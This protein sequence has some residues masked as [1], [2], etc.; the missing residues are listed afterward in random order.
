MRPSHLVWNQSSMKGITNLFTSQRPDG[1]GLALPS[2]SDPA[3]RNRLILAAVGIAT[4]FYAYFVSKTC[5]VNTVPT[6]LFG[7]LLGYWTQGQ[8][9][10]HGPLAPLVA[11]G[12]VVWKWK[13][14]LRN[15]PLSTSWSGLAVVV[16]A[17]LLYWVGARAANPRVIAISLVALIYGLT[18]YLAGWGWAKELWFACA[19]LLFMIPLTFLEERVSFPLRMFGA[20]VAVGV[21]NLFG[22]GVIQQGTAIVSQAGVFAPLGV[23][24]PCS[25]IRSL[26]ALM[27]LTSLYGYV[28]MD[29][30]WKKWVLF[31]ASIPLA[32]LG[33]LVRIITVALV[34]QGFGQEFAMKLYHD[35]SGFII[36]SLAILSMMA[37][38]AS[39]NL[40]YRELIDR[41]MEEETPTAVRRRTAK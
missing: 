18:L 37:L 26:V 9:Y 23:D 21:L 41:W 12:L 19:F 24:D 13:T 8:D 28:T 33:N 31:G 29:R 5:E 38:G 22:M 6:S 15:V 35:Y 27:A 1:A 10:A 11:I 34:A 7:W 39:L 4:I 36:F 2:F 20:S 14:K 3:V 25:G 32:V 30:G 40:H 16:G 17:L